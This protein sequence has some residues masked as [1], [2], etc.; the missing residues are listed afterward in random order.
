MLSPTSL[1][2]PEVESLPAVRTLLRNWQEGR[3]AHSLL[4]RG[5]A[6]QV[7]ES[8]ALQLASA[9]LKSPKPAAHPDFFALR[10]AKKARFITIGDTKAPEPNTMRHF[11]RDL[12]QS[13]HQG[14]YKVGLV[15]EADRMNPSTSNAFLKTLEEPPRETI[16]IL[17]TT[18]PYDLLDTI[19]SRCFQFRIGGNRTAIQDP[20]WID[21]LKDFGDFIRFV[22]LDSTTARKQPHR[23][24]FNLYSL[25]ARFSTV[26]KAVTDEEWER[27]EEN[28]QDS[29]SDDELQAQEVGIRKQFRDQ[30]LIDIENALHL[31][32][33]D[34]S[35]SVPYPA[36]ELAQSVDALEDTKAL[37]QLNMK[38]ETALETAFLEFLSIW[39]R[40]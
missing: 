6:L 10:P 16:L 11:L 37:L 13:S 35:H 7:L 21:W 19:R 38:D 40:H 26:L 24:L 22:H 18:R 36:L 8:V 28:L 34:F 3:L 15:F 17:L 4:L 14:G 31:K 1:L 25:L 39:A 9:I 29:L 30:F 5:D 27:I 2:S 23:S 33:I 32:A 12:N 20:A